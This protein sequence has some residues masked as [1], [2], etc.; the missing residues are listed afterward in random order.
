MHVLQYA[1]SFSSVFD[2]YT[3]GEEIS[4]LIFSCLMLRCVQQLSA[5]SICLLFGPKQ[6]VR[7]GFLEYFINKELTAVAKSDTLEMMSEP[8]PIKIWQLWKEAALSYTLFVQSS[9]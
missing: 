4:G 8:R 2:L 7:S 5:N 1:S 6:V 3:N 9:G